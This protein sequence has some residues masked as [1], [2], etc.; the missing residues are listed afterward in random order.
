MLKTTVRFL[1]PSSWAESIMIYTWSDDNGSHEWPGVAMTEDPEA[2]GW[3]SFQFPYMSETHLIFHDNH[4][5]QTSDLSRDR[6]GWYTLSTGWSDTRPKVMSTPPM[7]S[8]TKQHAPKKHVWRALQNFL[9]KSIFAKPKNE[10]KS[11]EN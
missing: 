7:S 10:Q 9:S 6:D 5:H 2:Q 11:D 8:E 4:G 1:R 3:Y